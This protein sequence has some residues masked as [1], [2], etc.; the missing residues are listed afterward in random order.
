M[1]QDNPLDPVIIHANK[2]FALGSWDRFFFLSWINNTSV[3]DINR[4][5]MQLQLAE[6]EHPD[7]VGVITLVEENTPMPSQESRKK[8]SKVMKD[9][10][11]LVKISAVVMKGTGFRSAAVRSVAV[12]LSILAK[13][14]YPHKIF[15]DEKSATKWV[16]QYANETLDWRI[17]SNTL[18]YSISTFSK[19]ALNISALEG[20]DD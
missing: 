2:D 4:L 20:G 5:S 16:E 14:A 12:G 9:S 18:T 15:S 10:S 7:G 8:L 13:Q 6:K 3:A 1:T 11:D 17:H 19:R